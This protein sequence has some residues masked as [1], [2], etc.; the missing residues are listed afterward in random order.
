[1]K[2]SIN[3]EYIDSILQSKSET[4]NPFPL[5]VELKNTN[6]PLPALQSFAFAVYQNY[7]VFIGGETIGFH[8]TSNNPQPFLTS[9]A[10]TLIWVID[11]RG[12]RTYSV[13][14]P[15][16]YLLSLAVTN[17]QFYQV[18]SQLFFCGG[19]T[20][21]DASKTAF[22]TT[23]NYLFKIDIVHLIKYVIGGG[24]GPTLQDIFPIVIQNDFFKV[25]GGELIIVNNI[26]YLVGGQDFEGDYSPGATG[27]YTNAIRKFSLQQNSSSWSIVNM[28]S[29]IDPVNLHRRDF[30]LV[31]YVA[32]DGSLECILLGGVFTKQGLSYNNPV[33]IKGLSEGNLSIAIGDLSQKC[34]QYTCAVVPMMVYP[35]A[36][37]VYGLL[38]GITYMEYDQD[39]EKLV[40]GDKGVPMPFSNLIDIII[41]STSES[42]E[43]VQMPPQELLPAYIG[44]NACFIPFAE[45]LTEG[46]GSIIDLNK[47]F[48][49]KSGK[50]SIGY[51]FGGILSD[52]PT[53]GTTP[54]GHV[55]T[56]ANSKLYVV[57][58]EL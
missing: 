11:I 51:L 10:N 27:N 57:S 36:G 46:S 4:V 22:D 7:W 29:L 42:I 28:D 47:V 12:E 50:I 38:G 58:I 45:Y 39:T 16:Q 1:M 13:P 8:G 19:F 32:L 2:N 6:I 40:V 54:S 48:Y 5:T 9:Y 41:S 31:P 26:F 52:G 14:I 17:P 37:M 49:Y 30:N 15:Q 53:S 44:S 56:Y 33:Y 25:T 20:V 55:N 3:K 18:D 23:S 24:T 21:S 43:F 34:N 35:G